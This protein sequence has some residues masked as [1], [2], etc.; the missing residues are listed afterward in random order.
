MLGNYLKTSL[1][2]IWKHRMYS[3]INIAG[4]AVGLACCLLIL[5]YVRD[6]L[7]FDRY[8]VKADR[9]FRLVDGFD[10]EGNNARFF[11]LSSAPFAPTLKREFPQVEDV[12][13]LIPS[14]R[15]MVSVGEKRSYEDRMIYADPSLFNIFTLPLVEGDPATALRAPN[16]L[17]I[18]RRIAAK[19][20]G[21][22]DPVGR[23][24]KV[25]NRDFL[26]T[27]LM[28]DMPRRSHFIADMFAS[29]A[30]LEQIS[31]L[32]ERYFE[33]W[34]RHEFYTYVL[35]RDAR[36]AATV[37]AQ[38]PGLIERHAAASVKTV[39]GST[40]SSRLQPL[41]DIHLRSHL[42]AEL[43]AN[44]DIKYVVAFSV[45]AAFI[46]LIGCVNFMNLA[47]ARAAT[48]SKEVGLRKVVGASRLQI[49]RQFLGE[50]YLFTAFALIL[51]VVLVVVALPG[52]DGL[53]GKAMG[54]GD[55]FDL[56][57]AA[58]MLAILFLVGL[59]SG[60]YP[61]F[62]ISAFEPGGLLKKAGRSAAGRSLLRKMLVVGQFAT[63]IV[64]IISTAVVLDQLDF[65]RNRKLGFDK[66]HVVVLPVRVKAIRTNIE[67][68]KAALKENPRVLSATLAIGV[69][70]GT[71]AGDSLDIITE[72][73][74][75]R[76]TVRMIY[77]DQDYVKTLGMEIVQGR[78]FSHEMST[79]ADQAILVNEA[80]V[81]ELGL[82]HPLDTGFEWDEKKGKVIGV[83]RDFQFQTLRQEITPLVMII[84]PPSGRIV[85]VRI[86]AD[87]I[88][89]TLAFLEKKWR[90]YDPGHPFEY[91][92]L[93]QTFDAIYRGEE[94]LGRVFSLSAGLA[95]FI[96]SLGLFG[97]ALFTIEERTKEI[98]IRKVLGASFGKIAVLL[99]RE[100]ALLVLLANVVAW[101][102]GYL[103]MRHWLQN[104]AYRV[105]MA[106]WFFVLSAGAAFLIALLTISAQTLRAA[107]ANPVK[108]LKYE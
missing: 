53:A 71:L 13:R 67:G 22:E 78:D 50:S 47:T 85:A 103:L 23:T 27:G 40:L 106:P 93:D 60:I 86:R 45:I 68:V 18:G 9:I 2:H 97:L 77:A 3:F 1:R 21:A 35:F 28:A 62:F 82:R 84:F 19:Y 59:A 42:Q 98:G 33:N 41:T 101:P 90:E 56:T 5:G 10:V 32:R 46:L 64:L 61:A 107:G 25:E 15:Q 54:L 39:L 6:E 17:V 89:E 87:H 37:E 57:T 51:A 100:F 24:L 99:S 79:D 16:S 108:A 31:D 55:M 34:V 7:A 43:G 20:F 96:A 66:S 8:H 69:P 95:I 91:S 63:S 76:V 73:G 14:Q 58:L 29:M 70:G 12:V 36:D 92:F 102:V 48:R 104:F 11:A 83:V 65:L 4:L 52:F 26:I 74:K 75:K 105:P 88:P 94:R 49:I 30:T 44:G 38:L 80:A 72:E 81:R